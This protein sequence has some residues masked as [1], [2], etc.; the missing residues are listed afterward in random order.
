MT[1]EPICL[2]AFNDARE[3]LFQTESNV[4]LCERELGLFEECVHDPTTYA[5]FLQLGTAT[6][7]QAKTKSWTKNPNKATYV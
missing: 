3:C 6:Q 1:F 7:R 2:D 5:R 4:R